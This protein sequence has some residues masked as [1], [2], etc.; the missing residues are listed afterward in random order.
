MDLDAI[1]ARLEAFTMNRLPSSSPITNSNSTSKDATLANGVTADTDIGGAGCVNVEPD[2]AKVGG[3]LSLSRGS[4]SAEARP[5]P[6]R[7]ATVAESYK[8]TSRKLLYQSGEHVH[9]HDLVLVL[10]TDK[11]IEEGRF[12]EGD[13]FDGPFRIVQLPRTSMDLLFDE[14]ADIPQE[15]LRRKIRLDLPKGSLGKHFVP[16]CNVRPVFR[17]NAEALPNLT[18]EELYTF[19]RDQEP[20]TLSDN[21]KKDPSAIESFTFVSQLT[22]GHFAKVNYTAPDPLAGDDCYI[23]SK[24]RGK[25]I[26]RSM[27]S[28]HEHEPMNDPVILGYLANGGE[29]NECEMLVVQYRV[30]WAGW[31]SQ[32]DSWE[33]AYQNIAAEF[34]QEWEQANPGVQVAVPD[35]VEGEEVEEEREGKK[36]GGPKRKRTSASSTSPLAK[37]KAKKLRKRD[38]VAT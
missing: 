32:D 37:K 21:A 19:H 35:K 1:E 17:C 29:L 24:L 18:A 13:I 10:R 8:E 3:E 38:D 6:L 23:V 28:E 16:I 26:I 22:D 9:R 5:N 12:D 25:R 20:F 11:Q 27:A 14:H 30:H 34:V 33:V 7:S 15:Q 31:S 2:D 36:K 4:S